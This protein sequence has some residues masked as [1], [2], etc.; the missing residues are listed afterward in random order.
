M[1]PGGLFVLPTESPARRNI[2]PRLAN[3]GSNWIDY[4]SC[5]QTAIRAQGLSRYFEGR[6]CR[7]IEVTYLQDGSVYLPDGTTPTD[8]ELDELESKLDEYLQQDAM[9]RQHIY[10][11]I[12]DALV[13]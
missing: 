5:L 10:E 12:D 3:D 1:G 8:E 7:P 13:T 2:V 11:T 4:K 9:T 6:L